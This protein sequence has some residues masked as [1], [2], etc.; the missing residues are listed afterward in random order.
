METLREIFFKTGR[1]HLFDV[2]CW[3]FDAYSPPL[4]DS[5]FISFFF[6]LTGR[7][8]GPAAGLKPEPLNDES[9]DMLRLSGYDDYI[10]NITTMTT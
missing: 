1:I 4:E 10:L 6:D 3:T 5:T 2:R 8:F 9:V 7:F